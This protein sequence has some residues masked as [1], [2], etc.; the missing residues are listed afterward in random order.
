MSTGPHGAFNVSAIPQ[1]IDDR[2]QANFVL[3]EFW[4]KFLPKTCATNLY[5]HLT[6][7]IKWMFVKICSDNCFIWIRIFLFP[8]LKI[9]FSSKFLAVQNSL[10]LHYADFILHY[11]SVFLFWNQ[12]M[13]NIER[14]RMIMWNDV[15][16]DVHCCILFQNSK[17]EHTF[18]NKVAA[19]CGTKFRVQ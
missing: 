1:S 8:E 4:W 5:F 12:L 2:V 6:I 15:Y 7:D 19:M 11:Q 14:Y 9:F 3:T 16:T 17:I 18:R 10:H 13:I